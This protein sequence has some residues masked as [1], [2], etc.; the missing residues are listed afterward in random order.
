V[1]SSLHALQQHATPPPPPPTRA[2]IWVN[3]PAAAKAGPP[4]Y[5]DVHPDTIP[6]APIPSAAGDGATGSHM[7][8]IAGVGVGGVKGPVETTTP[9]L[10]WDVRLAPGDTVSAPVPHGW[11]VLA[12]VFR[13]SGVFGAGADGKRASEGAMV[14]FQSAGDTITVTADAAT[15][16]PATGTPSDPADVA[17][18]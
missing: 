10:Y 13:G 14:V 16:A 12:Y 5:Q 2:Q 9:I 15:G 7:K 11:T 4:R 6:V 18:D 3:L 1:T 17:R 8:V